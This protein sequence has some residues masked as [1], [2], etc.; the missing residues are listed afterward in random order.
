[1][2]TP[3]PP[4]HFDVPPPPPGPPTHLPGLELRVSKRLLWVGGACYPLQNVARVYTLTIHPRRKEAV[5]R[6]LRILLITGA[7]ALTLTVLSGITMVADR[8]TG[9]GL[10]TFVWLGSAGVV[11]YAL[12]EMLQVLGAQSHHVLAVETSGPSQA[13]VTSRDPH[14]LNQLVA[15]IAHAIE[16]PETEFQVRVESITISPKNYYFGD[17]VNMY[18]GS[19]NVGMASA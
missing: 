3:E 7:V 8:D 4:G 15:R 12:I 11:V 16:N 1:M 19:G 9:S 14:H 17:N 18:G 5:L 10:M 6:F 2:T 13:V